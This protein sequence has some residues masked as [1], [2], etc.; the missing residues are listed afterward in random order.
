MYKIVFFIWFFCANFLNAMNCNDFNRFE[1]YGGHWYIVTYKKFTFAEANA[2]AIANGGYISVPDHEKENRFLNSLMSRDA[3]WIGIHDPSFIPNTCNIDTSVCMP[4]DL[5]YKTVFGTGLLYRNWDKGEPNNAIYNSDFNPDD[6]RPFVDPVGEYWTIMKK[7]GKWAD[8]GNHMTGGGQ[9]IKFQAILEFNTMPSCVAGDDSKDKP[10]ELI[11]EEGQAIC[12]ARIYH[13][14]AT[15]VNISSEDGNQTFFCEH[16][17]DNGSGDSLLYCPKKLETCSKGWE[18]FTNEG[19]DE[20][21]KCPHGTYDSSI[22]KCKREKYTCGIDAEIA[23]LKIDGTYKCSPFPCFDNSNVTDE[24]TVTGINDKNNDGWLEDGTCGGQI[25]IFNGKDRRC[26]SKIL[27]SIVKDCCNHSSFLF[28]VVKCKDYELHLDREREEDK[29]KY[30]GE[31]CSKRVFGACIKKKKT[32]CCF[33]SVFARTLIE[34]GRKQFKKGIS[35]GTAKSPNCRGFTPL[36][37]EKIDFSRIDLTIFTDSIT[38]E[39]DAS[40]IKDLTNR[41]QNTI[42][43][44]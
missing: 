29:C 26:R 28:G 44:Y 13:V 34:E 43:G 21:P 25:H 41:L 20:H 10:I 2:Y 16:S 32:Y 9:V 12:D 5:R 1:T 40:N 7:S 39:M 6:G 36:E 42:N 31:Y 23:C 24:D 33:N 15:D 35:W 14:N 17:D 38:N 18:Y 30:I 37:F 11:T 3:A 22:K 27:H 4:N 19:S 8:M